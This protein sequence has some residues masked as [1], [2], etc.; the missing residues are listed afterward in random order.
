[1]FLLKAPKEHA[2]FEEGRS[3]TSNR[4]NKYEELG[5][6]GAG[7]NGV[8]VLARDKTTNLPVAVK[9][10]EYES[11]ESARSKLSERD[12]VAQFEYDN[13]VVEYVE[14]FLVEKYSDTGSTYTKKEKRHQ[15]MTRMRLQTFF[16]NPLTPEPSSVELWLIQEYC[17]IGDL[18]H[19][20]QTLAPGKGLSIELIKH[21]LANMVLGLKHIH[22]RGI[23]HR[24]IKSLNVLVTR[25]GR[26]KICD[27]GR[28]EKVDLKKDHKVDVVTGLWMAPEMWKTE[29]FV[30]YGT[31]VDIWSLGITAIELKNTKPPFYD[32]ESIFSQNRI[33]ILPEVDLATQR[34][35]LGLPAPPQ[36]LIEQSKGKNNN[37]KDYNKSKYEMLRE[38]SQTESVPSEEEL[39][40]IMSEPAPDPKVSSFN[41]ESLS[42]LA[43]AKLRGSFDG[44]YETEVLPE[45]EELKNLEETSKLTRSSKKTDNAIEDILGLAPVSKAQNPRASHHFRTNKSNFVEMDVSSVPSSTARIKTAKKVPEASKPKRARKTDVKDDASYDSDDTYID[46]SNPRNRKKY[47]RKYT[48]KTTRSDIKDIFNIGKRTLKK[49]KEKISFNQGKRGTEIEDDIQS[50]SRVG[51][52]APKGDQSLSRLGMGSTKKKNRRGRMKGRTIAKKIRLRTSRRNKT[53]PRTANRKSGRGKNNFRHRVSKLTANWLPGTTDRSSL[54][55]D[56]TQ[57]LMFELDMKP[58]NG[59][60]HRNKKSRVNITNIYDDADDGFE[61]ALHLEKQMRRKSNGGLT[62]PFN[63]DSRPLSFDDIAEE[64]RVEQEKAKR[65]KA[66]LRRKESYKTLVKFSQEVQFYEFIAWCLTC[67]Q[68]KRPDVDQLSRHVFIR[69]QVK[70]LLRSENTECNI[71]QHSDFL[72]RSSAF[73]LSRIET[74][75]KRESAIDYL[76]SDD[77]IHLTVEEQEYESKL[78]HISEQQHKACTCSQSQ[79]Y[80]RQY[81]CDKMAPTLKKKVPS[82]YQDDLKYLF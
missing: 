3:T 4:C 16:P 51:Q 78:I 65:R 41:V 57:D 74:S 13:Y 67:D 29:G 64:E 73:E 79:K 39:D 62:Y 28:S 18:F 32:N 20:V 15:Q 58:E 27:F 48:S 24:D 70:S 33:A 43:P 26:V 53:T 80:I 23:V 2:K 36:E 5:Y 77:D 59:K 49:T 17:E 42:L 56:T 6:I 55:G 60:S 71:Q 54:V 63:H 52:G 47:N 10:M 66:K 46:M 12:F 35:Q 9:K 11:S 38:E 19:I 40:E 14:A 31:E 8:V 75:Q 30:S 7:G 61:S 25:C 76:E 81:L 22:G 68:S 34:E 50:L 72:L 69:D 1:M 44:F 37:Y 21:I 45:I 82:A